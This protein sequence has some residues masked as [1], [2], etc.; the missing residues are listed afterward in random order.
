MSYV[1]QVR[2]ESAEVISGMEMSRAVFTFDLVISRL[3]IKSSIKLLW[4]GF[5]RL[6]YAFPAE[7]QELDYTTRNKWV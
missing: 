1:R 7:Y 3:N 6:K 2:Y 4:L 5:Q